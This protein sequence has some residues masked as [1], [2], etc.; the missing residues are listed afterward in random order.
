MQRPSTLIVFH[1]LGCKH[2]YG[3][4]SVTGSGYIR[5]QQAVQIFI[6]SVLLSGFILS[7]YFCCHLSTA[8]SPCFSVAMAPEFII[9]MFRLLS[10]TTGLLWWLCSDL[11]NGETC[12]HL[13]F[14][15][16]VRWNSG[17]CEWLQLIQ[18]LISYAPFQEKQPPLIPAMQ[19]TSHL[20][21]CFS[22]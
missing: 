14:L 1:C 6:Q 8:D 13:V 20:F 4:F 12:F 17:L 7:F 18:G 21:E 19:C 16:S 9:M 11:I 22:A 10:L 2:H 15:F 5:V 3:D